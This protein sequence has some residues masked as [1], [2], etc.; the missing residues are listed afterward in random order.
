MQK[1]TT[2]NLLSHYF[3]FCFLLVIFP[4]LSWSE[5]IIASL[6]T[7]T[8]QEKIFVTS[9][10]ICNRTEGQPTSFSFIERKEIFL[11]V[12]LQREIE[13]RLQSW[14]KKQEELVTKLSTLRKEQKRLEE[15]Q[16]YVADYQLAAYK[17]VSNFLALF[18]SSVLGHVALARF[19]TKVNHC[20]SQGLWIIHR[21]PKR[22]KFFL[23]TAT[24]NFPL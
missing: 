21:W 16:N 22:I 7:S 10:L 14:S 5:I 6:L 15:V 9:V 8:E 23:P 20:M 17:T 11:L 24:L 12:L 4:F 13:R 1:L 2:L 3:V 19:A 18:V